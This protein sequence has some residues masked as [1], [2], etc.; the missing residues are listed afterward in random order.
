[1]FDWRLDKWFIVSSKP[2]GGGGGVHD[3]R[4]DEGVPHGFQKG[5]IFLLPTV[6]VIPTFMMNF[7][8]KLPI[9]DNILPISG[10]P[11]HV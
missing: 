7:G 4:M 8:R 5:S 3:L 9:F 10:K 2:G 1:M 6:A 11:T